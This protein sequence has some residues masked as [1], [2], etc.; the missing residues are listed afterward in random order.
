MYSIQSCNIVIENV[1]EIVI[2]PCK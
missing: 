1:T 2:Q